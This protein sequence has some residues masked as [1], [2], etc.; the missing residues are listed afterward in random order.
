MLLEA[1]NIRK[2]YPS[3]RF[4]HLKKT[5]PAVPAL[6]G[7]SL[8]LESGAVTGLTGPNGAGKSTL[9]RV[10][11]G[12]LIQDAGTILLDGTGTGDAAL[13]A[14]GAL[15]EAGGRSFYP[16]L[17]AM[18]N[19]EFFGAVCGLTRREVKARSAPLFELLGIG[20]R[21]LSK[22]LDALS[23]GAVQKLSLVRALIRRPR[24]LFLD[25]PARNLDMRSA[26]AFS[27]CL[28]DLA[29]REGL[30]ALYAGHAPAELAE[31]CGKVLVLREGKVAAVLRAP[32]AA[33]IA[34]ACGGIP[35]AAE[36]RA[37]E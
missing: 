11:A 3:R 12:R 30:A 2:S 35:P 25:E 20:G 7:I 33:G 22:R 19:L 37:A 15:A 8:T 13:R 31:V 29:A 9:L 17:T 28:K 24:I 14:R 16:R 26:A 32:T 23:E 4:F 1:R 21:D 36:R 6:N 27:S 34:A 18:E 10:L 5:G